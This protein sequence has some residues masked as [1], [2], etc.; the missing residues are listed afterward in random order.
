MVGRKW[1]T[2]WLQPEN[3]DVDSW[4]CNEVYNYVDGIRR[5]KENKCIER[6]ERFGMTV[7]VTG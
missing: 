3:E 6:A 5:T 2:A 7:V 4:L 1:M